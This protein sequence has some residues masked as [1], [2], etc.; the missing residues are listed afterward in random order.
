MFQC[1][2]QSHNAKIVMLVWTDKQ[3][4]EAEWLIS[5]EFKKQRV[6]GRVRSLLMSHWPTKQARGR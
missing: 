1:I 4:S 2:L 6:Q 5:N 3:E